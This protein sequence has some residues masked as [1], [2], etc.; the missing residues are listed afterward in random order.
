[1]FTMNDSHEDH[2]IAEARRRV[3]N[4]TP[5]GVPFAPHCLPLERARALTLN[6]DRWQEDEQAHVAGCRRC[7]RLLQRFAEEMP[8]LSLWTLIR[9]RL[10]CLSEDE[11]RSVLYHLDQGECRI[12]RTRDERMDAV[13]GQVVRFPETWALPHPTAAAAAAGIVDLVAQAPHHELEAQV[14]EEGRRITLEV[15]TRRETLRHKLVAYV[16]RGARGTQSVEGFL[17]LG[18]DLEGWFAADATFD[19]E[20]LYWALDGRCEE[21]L[22]SPL[23][24]HV[25]MGEQRALLLASADRVRAD[26]V[27]L[28]A[29]QNW[30]SH[31]AEQCDSIT[32]DAWQ[33]LCEVRNLLMD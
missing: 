29:W 31:A 28:A 18:P 13:I 7:G 3:R 10:G 8:H 12:C 14:F 5:A 4:W 22:V 26:P 15:R 1:M 6:P 19:V 16:L 21:V 27:A 23:C 32:D 33:L 2:L 11:D 17:V 25:L 30:V 9:R 24:I 20:E